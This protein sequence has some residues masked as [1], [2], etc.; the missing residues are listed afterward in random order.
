V[1][2]ADL[3]RAM[4]YRAINGVDA[5]ITAADVVTVF[6]N[7]P[8]TTCAMTKIKRLITPVGSGVKPEICGQMLTCDYIPVHAP[9]GSMGHNAFYY[10]RDCAVGYEI[11]IFVSSRLA[12]IFIKV[13]KYVQNEYMKYNHKIHALRID[14][15]T[16][17]NAALVEIYCNSV[18]IS[19]H[20][21]VPKKQRQNP[22]ERSVQTLMGCAVATLL[23]QTMLNATYWDHATISCIKSHNAYSSWLPT[24]CVDVVPKFTL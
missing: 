17:E 5:R 19:L 15:G 7:F 16:T 13:I 11:V 9:I 18:Q 20:P 8:C 14:A 10:F 24:S 3:A 2:P 22:I 12:D 6:Q 1:S 21:A 4:D 23:D